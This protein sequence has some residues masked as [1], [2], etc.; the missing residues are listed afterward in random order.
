MIFFETWS[1]PE[2]EIWSSSKNL[3]QGE[4]SKNG[5]LLRMINSDF[6]MADTAN[7]LACNAENLTIKVH[8]GYKICLFKDRVLSQ[9]FCSSLKHRQQYN[10]LAAIGIV[11]DVRHT[12]AQSI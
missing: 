1:K 11:F 10:I 4:V 5:Y 8:S 6:Y 7:L 2:N 9:Y 3:R 12:C